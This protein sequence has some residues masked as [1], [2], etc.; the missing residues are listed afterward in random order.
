MKKLLL[1]LLCLLGVTAV[2]AA[3][4]LYTVDLAKSNWPAK[5]TTY[6]NNNT[7]VDKKWTIINGS[8]NNSGWDYFRF[9]KKKSKSSDNPVTQQCYISSKF[10]MPE[11]IT[12]V[13]ISIKKLRGTINSLK[14]ESSTDADFTNPV[15]VAQAE[16]PSSNEEDPSLVKFNIDNPGTGLYY[17]L[18]MDLTNNTTSNGVVEV[19][20]CNFYGDDSTGDLT[21][22]GLA[23]SKDSFDATIGGTNAFPTLTNP[24]SLSVTYDSSDKTVATIDNEGKITLVGEGKTEISANFVSDGTYKS[25]NVK[26]TLNVTDPTNL[27]IF[28]SADGSGFTYDNI[29]LPE[30]LSNV[31]TV[32]N[33]YGLKGT[34]FFNGNKY[35]AKSVAYATIDLRAFLNANLTFSQAANK[36]NDNV[37]FKSMCSI[38]VREYGSTD[39]T[40]ISSPTSDEPGNSWTFYEDGPIDLSD[41]AGKKIEL[42]FMYEST[43]AVAGTWELKNIYV[44]GAKNPDINLVDPQLYWVVD[45]VEKAEYTYTLPDTPTYLNYYIG[46]KV[47]N[48]YNFNDI[49]ITSSN[50]AVAKVEDLIYVTPIAPGETTLTV[51]FPG[52]NRFLPATAELKLTVVGKPADPVFSVEEGEVDYGTKVTVKSQGATTMTYYI[53]YDAEGVDDVMDE[54]QGDTFTFTVTDDMTVTVEASNDNGS[55]ELEKVYL[56]KAPQ[57]PVFTPAAGEYPVGTKITFSS[58]NVN[59]YELSVFDSNFETLVDAQIIEGTEGEY[60]LAQDCIINVYA[61][62]PNGKRSTVAEAEYTVSN[63]IVAIFDFTTEGAYGFNTTNNNS[64]YETE[65]T[66]IV[67]NTYDVKI[68]M[69]GKYRHWTKNE[70]YDLRTYTDATMTF[71]APK[72]YA[73]TRIEFKDGIDSKL[74]IEGVTNKEWT[75]AESDEYEFGT[76]AFNCTGTSYIGGIN[77]YLKESVDALDPVFE[78]SATVQIGDVIKVRTQHE[79]HTLY[80]MINEDVQAAAAPLRVPDVADWTKHDDAEYTYTVTKMP[81]VIRAKVVDRKGNESGVQ[82]LEIAS[83]GTTSAIENITADDAQGEVEYYNLQGI[84]LQNPAAGTVVIRRQGSQVSKIR[85]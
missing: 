72:D 32:D 27:T 55:S 34:A 24:N 28:G 16:G 70:K 52:D 59:K 82:I 36:Y 56:V 69:S 25:D 4:P 45:G 83:D 43:T 73:I 77:V 53:E 51:S 66:E 74:N 19:Y 81:A 50:P 31:W 80:Y 61:I 9:G 40:K 62:L 1:T 26:Y 42:G 71:T 44:K 10:S 23:W 65:V 58:P 15:A 37:T 35:E 30:G 60:I 63:D 48:N 5:I 8:N 54:V 46:S 22:T 76:K 13:E 41:Y 79:H 38:V 64:V 6:T 75:P 21:D 18:A 47:D 2:W 7:S 67:D 14:I 39:W 20:A 3:E 57:A 12:S 68:D 78:A 85:L 11:K 33:T 49:E 84:R 17:R 29:L